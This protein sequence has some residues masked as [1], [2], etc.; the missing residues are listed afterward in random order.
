VSR[1]ALGPNQ[2]PIQWVLVA[3]SPGVKWLVHEADHSPPSS[4]KGK[5]K[6]SYT[7]TALYVFMAWCLLITRD[8]FTTCS[9]HH[10]FLDV[11]DLTILSKI[12]KILLTLYLKT[13]CVKS[14][15]SNCVLPK[16]LNIKWVFSVIKYNHLC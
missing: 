11:V 4:A 13:Q 12:C 1:P 2:L 7:S 9:T 10:N 6:W 3:L 15:K 8:N 14:H 16:F 5:K